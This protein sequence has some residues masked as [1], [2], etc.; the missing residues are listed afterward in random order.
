MTTESNRKGQMSIIERMSLINEVDLRTVELR[1]EGYPY[2]EMHKILLQ[3][4]DEARVMHPN[5]LRGL[6]MKGGRLD[7]FYKA[8]AINETKFRRKEAVDILRA[9]LGNA[10][11]TL[12]KVMSNS[13]SDMVQF[14]AAK[15]IINRMLGEPVKPMVS[16]PGKDPAERILSELGLIDE[17]E[18]A[19]PDAPQDP[20]QPQ[21]K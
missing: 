10:S 13:K 11:R 6:F 15:E 9:H 2:K 19:Q 1:Y 18:L 4:F 8:Y 21:Q 17:P 12:V 16:I 14:L 3:E 5:R 7:E 20:V